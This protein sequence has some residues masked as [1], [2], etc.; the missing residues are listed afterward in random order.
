MRRRRVLEGLLIANVWSR[1]WEP[2]QQEVAWGPWQVVQGLPGLA[3]PPVPRRTARGTACP[4]SHLAAHARTPWIVGTPHSRTQGA[5][6]PYLGEMQ[7]VPY[8]NFDNTPPGAGD[9]THACVC[10]GPAC[11]IVACWRCPARSEAPAPRPR[12]EAYR[13]DRCLLGLPT[14]PNIRRNHWPLPTP[15]RAVRLEVVRRGTPANI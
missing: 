7:W 11:S 9:D 8:N 3:Q 14:Q 12:A 13:E 10:P 15:T 5:P 6:L 2:T 4:G 1:L